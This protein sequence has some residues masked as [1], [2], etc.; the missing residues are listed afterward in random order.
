M[1]KNKDTKL[2]TL[3][4]LTAG[5]VKAIGSRRFVY[6]KSVQW[7]L[8]LLAVWFIGWLIPS[9]ITENDWML[10]TALIPMIIF[11][12]WWVFAGSKAEKHFYEKVKEEHN[13][14]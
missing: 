1:A 10:Y 14:Q 12:I 7:K 11:L 3:N 5:E 6:S 2:Y 4:D 13:V 9:A 8:L